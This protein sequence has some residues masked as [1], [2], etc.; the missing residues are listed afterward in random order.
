MWPGGGPFLSVLSFVICEITETLLWDLGPPLCI[1]GLNGLIALFCV[2]LWALVYW[3]APA[4]ITRCHRL[5]GLN[6]NS[7]SSNAEV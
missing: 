2:A 4:D 7:F 3:F 1:C 6:K 5:G